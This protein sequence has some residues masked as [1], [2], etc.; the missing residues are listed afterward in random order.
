[1]A[2]LEE[3]VSRMRDRR[4]TGER[5]PISEFK[6][7]QNVAPLSEDKQKFREWNNKCVSAMG[8]V[9][10]E[11]HERTVLLAQGLQG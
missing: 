7:I 8:Q 4:T 9:E 2:S 3:S 11:G 5:K 6:V 1:M 10:A